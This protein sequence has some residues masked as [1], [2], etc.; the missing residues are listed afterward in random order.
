MNTIKYTICRIIGLPRIVNFKDVIKKAFDESDTAENIYPGI[1]C[2]WDHTPRS[3]KKGYVY[4]NFS[5]PLFK[6][7]IK[8]ILSLV[9]KIPL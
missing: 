2:G 8:S 4:Y 7:H 9:Q 3:G 6:K 1:I 5:I